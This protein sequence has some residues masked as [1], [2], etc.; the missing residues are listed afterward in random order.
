M[1]ER[2]NLP[3]E[4][5]ILI[6]DLENIPETAAPE[7]EDSGSRCVRCDKSIPDGE[8]YCAECLQTMQDYPVSVGAWIGAVLSVLVSLFALFVS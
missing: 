5:D 1:S 2:T 3:E 8:E 6:Q 7:P 4:P